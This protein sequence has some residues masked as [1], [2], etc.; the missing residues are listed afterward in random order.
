M[1]EFTDEQYAIFLEMYNNQNIM[2]KKETAPNP[3]PVPPRII[4]R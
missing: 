2:T 4:P 3:K 1:S